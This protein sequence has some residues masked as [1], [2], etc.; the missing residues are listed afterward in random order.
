MNPNFW[1]NRKRGPQ[2]K[3]HVEKRVSKLRGRKRDQF[4]KEWLEKISKGRVGIEPWNK[5]LK[6][7]PLSE[8]WKKSISEPVSE[9]WETHPKEK[10]KQS[11]YMKNGG[12]AH[13][14]SFIRDDS[15]PEN[16]LFILSCKILPRPIHKYSV[17]RIGKGKKS[18]NADIAD[19]S[20]GVIIEYDGW[21]HFNNEKAKER[22]KNRQQELEEEG[23]KFIRYNIFQKFPTLEQVKEDIQKVLGS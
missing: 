5:G 21:Y 8:E 11:E 12:A 4:S 14:N 17:Y 16:E 2:T 19:S 1:K 22:H 7:G 18:Y 6:T 13:A 15:K 9:W 3:E 20:L 10:E 23:W